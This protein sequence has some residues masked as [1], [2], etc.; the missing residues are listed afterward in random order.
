RSDGQY[1][2]V[3]SDSTSDNAA[4]VQWTSNGQ[5]DQQWQIVAG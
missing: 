2:D 3:K 1:V 4:I 5:N